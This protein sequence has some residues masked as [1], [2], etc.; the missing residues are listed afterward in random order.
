MESV[1]AAK[2]PTF[3]VQHLSAWMEIVEPQKALTKF[4]V[5]D[6]ADLQDSVDAAHAARYREVRAQIAADAST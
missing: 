5:E 2:L 1:V 6:A 4:K 3:R